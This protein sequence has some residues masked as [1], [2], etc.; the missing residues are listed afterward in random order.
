MLIDKSIHEHF[1]DFDHIDLS[2]L[3]SKIIYTIKWLTL[4]IEPIVETC[5]LKML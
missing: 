1:I 3:F 5:T 2:E 4:K